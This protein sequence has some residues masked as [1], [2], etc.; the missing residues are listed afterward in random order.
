MSRITKISHWTWVKLSDSW[1]LPW[2][3]CILFDSK[4]ILL[5]L[6]MFLILWNKIFPILIRVLSEDGVPLVLIKIQ[7]GD[8]V[9]RMYDKYGE[10]SLG[11]KL[12]SKDH[13]SF[14]STLCA[15]FGWSL[16][17]S[18]YLISFLPFFL[19]FWYD[20]STFQPCKQSI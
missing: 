10:N 17:L 4:V 14:I 3:F 9:L 16:L 19:A 6:G 20:L 1:L 15:A 13:L 8:Q 12:G 5:L 7:S 11:R 2:V 18:P